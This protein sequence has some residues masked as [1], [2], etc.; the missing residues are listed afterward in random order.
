MK[1]TVIDKNA[2]TGGFALLPYQEITNINFVFAG[3]LLNFHAH[4]C[5]FITTGTM[6]IL[7]GK[8]GGNTAK[9]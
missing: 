3:S 9:E 7:L 2:T 4:A 8:V 6:D 5:P 1:L